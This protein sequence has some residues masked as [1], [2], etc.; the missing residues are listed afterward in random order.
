[1]IPR[2]WITLAVLATLAF[3]LANAVYPGMTRLNTDF[4][5]YFTAAREAR[6]GQHFER[7]YEWA[8][9]QKKKNEAGIERPLGS[10]SPASPLTILPFIPLTGLP[11][12]R[13]KQVWLC[14]NLGFLASALWMMAGITGFRI[15]SLWL[16]TFGGYVALRSNFLFGQ[17]YVFLL[18]L[19]TGALRALLRKRSG[20]SG[21]LTGIAF[22]LKS[23]SGP[24]VL[25]FAAKR[26][27]RAVAGMFLTS[28]AFGAV[29]VA[30]FGRDAVMYFVAQVAPRAVL[31]EIVNPFHP[32]NGTV[33]TF[34]HRAFIPEAELNPHP[35]MEA[36]G[37]YFFLRSLF[38][39]VVLGLPVLALW[40]K[41]GVI[42][43]REFAWFLVA[44]LLVSPNT[45]SYTFVLLVLPVALLLE[46]AGLGARIRIFTLYVLL[47]LPLWPAWSWLFPKV[48]LLA[49]LYAECGS[50]SWRAIRLRPALVAGAFII[51][52]SASDAWLR[53]RD[54]RQEPGR[55]MAH[56]VTE[57]GSLYA[58]SPAFSDD[59]MMFTFMQRE[60]YVLRLAHGG[61][62]ETFEFAG[63]AFHPTMPDR[64]GSVYFEFAAEGRNRIARCYLATRRLEM[65][66]LSVPHPEEPAISHNGEALVVVSDASLWLTVDGK[67]TKLA[68][69]A[70]AHDPAFV[71][72]DKQ[73]VYV[74][75]GER[76]ML[77]D[78]DSKVET[79]ITSDAAGTSVPAV[80]PDGLWLSFASRETGTMQV[81]VQALRGGTKI[82][83]T[84]GNCNNSQPA[85]SR[86]SR[87]IA[88]ASDCGRGFG[89]T[90][91]YDV[92]YSSQELRSRL[93]SLDRLPVS[94][95]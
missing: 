65:L 7:T 41:P 3:F 33:S 13:A 72:G 22:M 21:V 57:A 74:A 37:A 48:L 11:P 32:A 44:T 27:S 67:S 42:L 31:G 51:L 15:S 89:L 18:W 45:A 69:P 5:N 24:F 56:A 73:I 47:T 40:P 30:F 70:P 28:A 83:L 55:T 78:L 16:L 68:A 82:R 6:A 36:P 85:W 29:A 35:W 64:G 8:W 49:A 86:D 79:P 80:S 71:P 14:L 87:R 61:G 9:F 93:R 43:K 39:L 77:F 62:I 20:T 88:F 66:P 10:Y 60:R 75:G 81:W 34:L 19:I 53:T 52:I 38:P 92:D 90:A 4:P 12:L 26:N 95:R 50:G 76:I 1:M 54:Y 59:G 84:G 58:A 17:Y 46:D 94:S 91:L 63:H 23:Y 25:L 2:G